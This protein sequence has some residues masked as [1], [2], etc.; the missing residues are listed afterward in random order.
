MKS[1][2][3]RILGSDQMAKI[4]KVIDAIIDARG[5]SQDSA[6]K[7][8]GYSGKS[9]LSSWRVKGCQRCGIGGANT[10]NVRRWILK[11]KHVLKRPAA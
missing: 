6:M 4:V 3:K 10:E 7:E 1:G 11:W 9:V 5:I 8:M 2:G